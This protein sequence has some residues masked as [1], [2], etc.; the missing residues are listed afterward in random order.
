MAQGNPERYLI[1]VYGRDGNLERSIRRPVEREPVTEGDVARLREH[2]LG[3]TDPRFR[4][5]VEAKWADAPVASLKPAFARMTVDAGG[6]LWV[7][8]PRV[9]ESDP[10]FA[11]VFDEE[12]R[13]LG[14]IPLPGA[15]RITEIGLDYVLGVARDSD[16]GLEQ[17]RLYRLDRRIDR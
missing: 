14:R 16:T 17:V 10:G 5:Q 3:E 15:F 7:E 9:L 8:A 6:A 4:E 2:E 12:G 11:D 13:L 1:Q